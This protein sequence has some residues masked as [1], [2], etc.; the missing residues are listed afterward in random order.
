MKNNTVT[1]TGVISGPFQP[2]KI[3]NDNKHYQTTVTVARLDAVDVLPVIISKNIINPKTDYSGGRVRI[4]GSFR[5]YT[6]KDAAG[7]SC[8]AFYI[9]PADICPAKLEDA[10]AVSITGYVCNPPTVRDDSTDAIIT[11]PRRNGKMDY[12]PVTAREINAEYLSRLTVGERVSISGRIQPRK[13]AQDGGT[14]T[15]YE[16]YTESIKR[17]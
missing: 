11:V 6:H 9:F 8:V 4:R 7:R 2:C 15:T 17:A 1:I 10:N 5:S 14:C 16:L 12:I 13:Y 3:F